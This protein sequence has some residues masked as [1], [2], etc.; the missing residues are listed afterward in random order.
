MVRQHLSFQSS[1]LFYTVI[2]SG[3]AL[4]VVATIHVT[5][6]VCFYIDVTHVPDCNGFADCGE[7]DDCAFYADYCDEQSI[8]YYDSLDHYVNDRGYVDI[9][10]LHNNRGN[11]GFRDYRES[12]FESGYTE[13]KGWYKESGMFVQPD[14][15]DCDGCSF[16]YCGDLSTD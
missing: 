4:P 2:L 14:D 10:A 13:H 16:H 12:V 3:M 15:Y 11:V 6:F 1:I 5:R 8:S 7:C 9:V